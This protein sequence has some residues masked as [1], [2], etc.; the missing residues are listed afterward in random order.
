MNC[1]LQFFPTPSLNV[2]QLQLQN[3][4]IHIFQISPSHWESHAP[5]GG[6]GQMD[7]VIQT[8]PFLCREVIIN[9]ASGL[10]ILQ[11]YLSIAS[12]DLWVLPLNPDGAVWLSMKLFNLNA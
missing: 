9:A 4:H 7:D 11:L 6:K 8:A 5:A 2:E 12:A 10:P 3:P 1:F